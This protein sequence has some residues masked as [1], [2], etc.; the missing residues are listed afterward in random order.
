MKILLS[1]LLSTL[2]LAAAPCDTLTALKLP[3]TAVTLAKVEAGTYPGFPNLPAFCR[4]AATL[5]PTQDSD[6]KIEVWLPAANW[7]G[8]LQAVGNGGWAGTISYPAMAKALSQGYATTS[9][10]TGHATP[11]AS[12][13]MGH[14]EKLVDFG[15]RAVHEMT[16]QA[17]TI[18]AAFYGAPA[19]KAYWNGCSTGGK[20]GLMEA[21]R[22]PAD[23]DGIIA[24]A[25]ANYMSHLQVW[26]LWV[27]KAVHET[28]E[29]Y[30]PP[31]K[32]PLIH[33]AVL[34][35]CDALD[36][37]KDGVL[38]DPRR[39]HVDA[40]LLECCL[41][42][43]Q[44]AA[45]QKLYGPA[46]NPRTGLKIFPGL[47]PGSEMGWGGLAGPQP[48]SIPTDTFKYVV[49]DNPQWD[50]KT[51]DFDKDTAALEKKF[52][53]V[54]DA[55]NPDLSAFVGRGGKLILY[56]GWN[57]QLIAPENTIDYFN[58]AA[59]AMGQAKV[60]ESMRLFM[61]PGMTHCS[62]GDGTSNFDMVAE[63]ERWVEKGQAPERVTAS[64]VNPNRTRPLCRYP[65]V[66]VY[67]GTGS[68]DDAANFTC[69]RL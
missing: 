43:A 52:E 17:K 62:G 13:A 39:C 59:Y 12:F 16:L 10:D 55:V 7:N 54:V 38:E 4:V 63:M 15:Y 36:G 2:P 48:M 61:V 46:E 51:I 30:I 11:G 23:Y 25:P 1:A 6:I 22:F 67:K 26:S 57:D 21:Q 53:G 9:T 66:A 40:K 45:A 28:N 41:T 5:T 65:M 47:E 8:K 37:V 19:T 58:N 29:S 31:D 32:Y 69:G 14:P 42:P 49:Y 44:A 20:Q 33:K 60:D 3:N 27:P 18:V 64:R 35:A 50:W 34:E 24:G 68:T 56:H